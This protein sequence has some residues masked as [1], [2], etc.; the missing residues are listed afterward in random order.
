MKRGLALA[1]AAL[2][3]ACSPG[4]WDMDPPVRV[5]L[6]P[7]AE[8]LRIDRIEVRSA[9]YNP[10]DAFSRSFE[11]AVRARTDACAR[12]GRPVRAVIFI[13]ELDRHS[14]LTGA[15]GGLALSGSVD[16]LDG[17]KLLARFPVRIAA[18]LPDGGMDDR[19]RI[20]GDGFGRAICAELGAG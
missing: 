12:G 7:G 17:R 4:F 20:A 9:F 11:P 10:P 18:P 6:A 13:H 8:A 16:L 15:D 2:T 3:G 19:R 1:A 5:P 14:D